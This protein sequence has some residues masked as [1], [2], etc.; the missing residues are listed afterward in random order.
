[1]VGRGVRRATGA[2]VVPALPTGTRLPGVKR[3]HGGQRCTLERWP[4]QDSFAPA[5]TADS[6]GR[7]HTTLQAWPTHYPGG[8]PSKNGSPFPNESF[9]LIKLHQRRSKSE[10]NLLKVSQGLTPNELA[11]WLRKD[12]VFM[13]LLTEANFLKASSNLSGLIN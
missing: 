12:L 6:L 11:T 9:G 3:K 5:T 4:S 7:R 13:I 10:S 1:M 2:A 8:C